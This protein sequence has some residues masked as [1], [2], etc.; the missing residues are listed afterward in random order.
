VNEDSLLDRVTAAAEE[1]HLSQNTLT[2]YRRTWLKLI[3][4][5]AAEGLALETLPSE[6][7]GEFYEEATRGRSASHHLQAKAALALL[8]HV[9]DST[10]PFAEC[11]AP[12]FAPEKTEL[13]YHTASQLGHLLRELRGDR[14]SYFGHLTYH[15]ATALFFT[16]CRFHEWARLTMDRLVREPSGVRI[17]ARLQVK[18]GSFRDL[19]PS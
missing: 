18:G 13:R 12:K 17:A 9:L 2:A 3:A 4:L 8:Y 6:R 5:A 11:P 15:L 10:N 19:P 14:R 1:R 16:G 7:A